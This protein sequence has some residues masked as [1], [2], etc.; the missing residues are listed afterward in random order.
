MELTIEQAQQI[1][2]DHLQM[3]LEDNL[4]FEESLCWSVSSEDP[5][6]DY[7]CTLVTNVIRAICPPKWNFDEESLKEIIEEVKQE[8]GTDPLY[9][10][11]L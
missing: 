6:S 1:I 2:L 9:P 3:E 8:T 4:F 7:N 10:D 5:D 11:R